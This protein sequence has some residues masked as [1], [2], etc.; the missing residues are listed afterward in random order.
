MENSFEKIADPKGEARKMKEDQHFAE[1]T[2]K[3]ILQSD[4]IT[5]SEK[6]RE[7]LKAKPGK[8]LDH[9]NSLLESL[10]TRYPDLQDTD[11]KNLVT[12]ALYAEINLI[13]TES[14]HTEYRKSEAHGH[15]WPAHDGA[16]TWI[17]KS[18]QDDKRE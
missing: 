4:E 7:I 12:L 6:Y 15:H 13:R 16:G 14:R 9:I 17:E 11:K 5:Q 2:S 18:N 1:Q 8:L 3:H 10:T